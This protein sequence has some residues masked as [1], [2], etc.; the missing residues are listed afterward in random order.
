MK[1]RRLLQLV[2]CFLVLSAF[3]SP[4]R[5]EL[6]VG[7]ETKYGEVIRDMRSAHVFFVPI[8]N[9]EPFSNKPP[10]HF[11]MVDA[12]TNI[13]GLYSLWSFVIPSLAAFTLLLWVMVRMTREMLG[14]DAAWWSAL[15]VG[16]SLLMW[17]SAQTA[18][19][20]MSFTL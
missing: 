10:I 12:L 7:D 16:S 19:M 11:W 4:M 18:R 13:F 3:L 15:A 2:L 17:G 5:R 8:L 1:R 9:G 20:D 6:Y 14:E